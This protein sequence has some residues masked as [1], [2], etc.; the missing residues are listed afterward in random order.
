MGPINYIKLIFKYFSFDNN[1]ESLKFNLSS[2]V[3]FFQN[4]MILE[5]AIT[6]KAFNKS[7]RKNVIDFLRNG[8]NIN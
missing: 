5:I 4:P 3:V 8:Q 2:G 1:L 7:I 6:Y